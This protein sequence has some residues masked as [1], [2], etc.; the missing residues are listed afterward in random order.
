MTKIGK[1]TKITY[2][3]LKVTDIL[4]FTLAGDP[5]Y[6][7]TSVSAREWERRRG[8]SSH[9]RTKWHN[10][11]KLYCA[12]GMSEQQIAQKRAEL[13]GS[14]RAGRLAKKENINKLLNI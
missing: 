14:P 1:K 12:Q 4:D 2:T 7:Q 13:Q 6:P 9:T 8:G 11:E 3:V 10:L 5:A